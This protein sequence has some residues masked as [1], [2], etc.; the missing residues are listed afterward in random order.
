MILLILLL[1]CGATP[2]A[3]ANQRIA[4]VIGNAAYDEAPLDNPVRDAAAISSRLRSLGFDVVEAK[5]ATLKEMQR[6]LVEFVTQI[7]SGAT[8]MVFYA[9][10]GIQANGRNYLM[11]VDA[12]LSSETALRFE[13]MEM[14][15]I[16]EEME[17]TG[18]SINLIVVDACRNNPFERKFR[19]GSRGLAVVDAA[20]GTLIAYATAP[21]QVASDGD[22]KNGLYTSALLDA[23]ETPNL[24]VEEVFKRVRAEVARRSG[25][26]Q[27]PWES[28]SLL[29]DFVF[30]ASDDV[31]APNNSGTALAAGS[32]T[33]EA[34]RESLFWS[35]IKDSDSVDA[36]ENYLARY[37]D[38]TFAT[39]ANARLRSLTTVADCSDLSGQWNVV[40]EGKACA[41]TIELSANGK[42]TY[43]MNYR[44]C[45]AM[46]ALTNVQGQGIYEEPT[47]KTSWSSFPCAGE[48]WFE[49]DNSCEAGVGKVVKRSG[50]PGVCHVFVSKEVEMNVRRR[51]E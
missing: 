15:D 20:A 11:P 1:T 5:D 19:G 3:D 45:G 29:G 27:I 33:S 51:A 6:A 16:L 44:I 34:D 38:G 47:L 23:L 25:N 26:Q 40:V 36:F 43:I 39:I 30:Y 4:L 48:T 8:A 42:D 24:K 28:S 50:V 14:N 31:S 7:E 17:R 35:S 46:G 49:F 10:H 9:G 18:S 2:S 37:P 32:V 21:G 22:G 13:A 41:D 12:S